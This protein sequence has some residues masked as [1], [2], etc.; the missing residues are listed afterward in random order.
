[1]KTKAM[2]FRKRDGL[3]NNE[4]WTYNGNE[5]EVVDNFNYLGTVLKY[6][7][8]FDLNIEH[9]AGKSLKALNVL[10]C[11]CKKIPLK[12]KTLCQLFDSFVGSILGYACEV[13]GS[14][15]QKK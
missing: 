4:T 1:M 2:V 6:T 3:L 14:P 13:W 7:G 15:G 10:L 8:S 12:P 11:N 5:I 9:L